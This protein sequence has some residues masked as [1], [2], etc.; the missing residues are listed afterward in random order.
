M[1]RVSDCR[2]EW[3]KVQRFQFR[4][5]DGIYAENSARARADIRSFICVLLVWTSGM[6]GKLRPQQKQSPWLLY[7]VWLRDRG[8]LVTLMSTSLL[9]SVW[10]LW[11]LGERVWWLQRNL[12]GDVPYFPLFRFHL[13][14]KTTSFCKA[15]IK[16]KIVHTTVTTRNREHKRSAQR[17]PYVAILESLKDQFLKKEQEDSWL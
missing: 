4:T 7:L 6:A 15:S 13:C 14:L 16:F 3:P 11:W 9:G 1:I 8:S 5:Q 2:E 10:A 12:A 17:G